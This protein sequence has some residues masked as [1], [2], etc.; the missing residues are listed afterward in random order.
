MTRVMWLLNHTSAR[1][2]DVAMLERIGVREIFLPKSHPSEPSFRSASVD[3]SRD[4]SLR[5]TPTELAVLNAQNWYRKPSAEAWEIA[6]RHFDVLF[7]CIHHPGCL[8]EYA[9]H[10]TGAVC[11]RAFG[12]EESSSYSR[13]IAGFLEDG[14]EAIDRLGA[15]F[16]LA[17]AYAHLHEREE[18]WLAARRVSLPLGLA[19]AGIR[20]GWTGSDPRVL[21]VCPDIGVNDYYDAIY[22]DFR[23]H[24]GDLPYVVGG[25]QPLHHRDSNILGYVSREEYDANMSS[26]RVM[27]YHSRERYH[28]HYHPFEAI[29]VGM[30]LVFMGGGLLDRL[31]GTHLPGRATSVTHARSLLRRVLRGDQTLI[32]RIRSTQGRLLEAMHPDRC[33]AAWHAG[34]EQIIDGLRRVAVVPQP[35][36]RTTKDGPKI[37]VILPIDYRGGTRRAATA[38][39]SAIVAGANRAGVQPRIVFGVPESEQP[40]AAEQPDALPNGVQLRR[41]HWRALNSDEAARA[42]IYAGRSSKAATDFVVPEDGINSFLDCDLWIFVS[43]RIQRP[44]LPI[45][46]LVMLVYDYI[47]RCMPVI[48]ASSAD[49]FIAVARQSTKVFTTSE[50]TRSKAIQYAGIATDKVECLPVAYQ[51]PPEMTAFTAAP[52]ARA[53]R[54]A[55]SPADRPYLL[56]VTNVARHKNH[57]LALEALARYYGRYRGTLECRVVGL[58]RATLLG[59]EIPHLREAAG[60]VQRAAILRRNLRLLGHVPDWRYYEVLSRAALLLHPAAYDNG[61][62]A[63]IDAWWYGVPVLAND[64]PAMREIDRGFGIGMDWCDIESPDEVARR[65]ALMETAA[66][67]VR[68]HV[69]DA[70]RKARCDAMAAAA[71]DAYWEAITKC[72]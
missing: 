27:Y 1:A 15:R 22:D 46:P 37:A 8:A 14:R 64:Y 60:I 35:N 32:A 21:F 4:E 58:D 67:A 23:S 26:L 38:T 54:S 59:G 28:V 49:A 71:A 13:V 34:H 72:L 29:R 43:D 33:E 52:D 69:A 45:R 48:D 36:Q 50:A 61:S 63:A 65:I 55:Q 66:F 70:L 17:E 42:M 68:E 24:F 30:P 25:S 11:L 39:I 6:N 9:R 40:V 10:F 51:P 31:G 20:D 5:L 7:F 12:V 18:P 56:W 57:T 16:W 47:Q 19:D 44:V 62:Y 3:F 41:F 2:F 53:G